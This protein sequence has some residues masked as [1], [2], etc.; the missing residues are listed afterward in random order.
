MTDIK[1]LNGNAFC[2][3]PKISKDKMHQILFS[4]VFIN[5]E[6]QKLSRILQKKKEKMKNVLYNPKAI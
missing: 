2:M 6:Y 1:T 4:S 3:L 5:V